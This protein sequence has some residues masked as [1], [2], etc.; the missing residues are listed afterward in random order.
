M[1]RLR[2]TKKLSPEEEKAES[3]LFIGLF[4]LIL[5]VI[6][7]FTGLN[8]ALFASLFVAILFTIIITDLYLNVNKKYAIDILKLLMAVVVSTGLMT[9]LFSL[10]MDIPFDV[11]LLIGFF[12]GLMLAR[13]MA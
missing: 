8:F 10:V 2:G 5:F 6:Y 7:K 12:F 11:S 13:I 4:A 9:V 1:A 3:A